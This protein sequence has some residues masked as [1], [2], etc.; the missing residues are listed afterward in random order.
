[1][2]N[3]DLK[4]EVHAAFALRKGHKATLLSEDLTQQT[5]QSSRG[6]SSTENKLA[7]K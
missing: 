7:L 6:M 3:A 1:M 5:T 2:E 4:A